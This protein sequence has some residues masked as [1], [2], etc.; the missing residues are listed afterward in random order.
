MWVSYDG[1]DYE[2]YFIQPDTIS[3]TLTLNSDGTFSYTPDSDFNGQV[4]FDYIVSDGQGGQDTATVTVNVGPVNDAPVGLADTITTAFGTAVTLNVL[5]NDTDVDADALTVSGVTQGTNGSVV[6]NTDN[7]ITYTP[8]SGFAGVD[9]FTYIANDGTDDAFPTT[10]TVTVN[11]TSTILGTPGDDIL[12]GT[13]MA[14]SIDGLG[15]SDWIYGE[16][17]DDHLWGGDGI[18]FLYGGSDDDYLHGQ[19]GEDY[20]WGEGGNDHLYGGDGNDRLYGGNGADLL[21]GGQG[22]DALDGGEFTGNNP[23]NVADYQNDP[24][25]AVGGGN[26]IEAEIHYN[27]ANPDN[28]FDTSQVIDGWG[29]IDTINNITRF[30]GSAF[31]DKIT[32]DI[33]DNDN[34]SD[35][36]WY[37]AGMDG[38]DEIIGTPGEKIRAMYLEDPDLNGD[39]FGVNINLAAGT[40]IDGWGNIDTLIDIEG[41]SGSQYNDLLLGSDENDGFVGT[42]GNDSIDGAL[43]WDWVSYGWFSGQVNFGGVDIDLGS[44]SAQGRDLTGAVLFTDSL[45]NIEGAWGTDFNDTLIGSDRGDELVGEAGDDIL[46]GGLGDDH[47]TGG[48]GNDILDGGM[49]Q[50]DNPN[51]MADYS[52]DPENAVG[53][54]N[55]IEAEI[56]Y[57]T[58]NPVN[59]FDS[60]QVIDGWG[61]TDSLK[62]INR[63]KGSA[64]DDSITIAIQDAGGTSNL[65][66]YVAGMA[67]NDM[68]TGT[69]GESVR[70][71]YFEDP[72]LNG[73]GFGVN[74]D[75]AAGTAMDGWGNTDTLINI[76]GVSGSDFNDILLGSDRHDGFFG[77]LGN[78]IIDGRGNRDYVHYGGLDDRGD[79]NGVHIDLATGVVNG[80]NSNSEILFTD[81]LI[82][83]TNV[84]GSIFNDTITGNS[85]DNWLQGHDGDDTIT[86]GDGYDSLWGGQGNDSLNGAVITDNHPRTTADYGRDPEYANPDVSMAWNNGIFAS[87]QYDSSAIN[88]FFADGSDP[89]TRSIVRDGWGTID[90]IQDITRFKGSAFNDSMTISIV[91]QNNSSDLKWYL[92]GLNGN[93]V[94]TGTDG[95]SISAMYLD[96]PK[97]VTIDLFD[98]PDDIF[99]GATN[100]GSGYAID[101]WEKID[102]LFNIH[103]VSGS[104]H[105][106]SIEGSDQGDTIYGSFGDDI[107]DGQAG[108]DGLSYVFMSYGSLDDTLDF[109]GVEIDLEAGLARGLNS[110]HTALFTDTFTNIEWFGGSDKGDRIVGDGLDNRLSGWDGDD[111]LIGMGGNDTLIGEVGNDILEG[112]Q[113]N[114]TLE[115]GQGS[116]F[117]YGGE[118]I[119]DI[120]G[121]SN[122]PGAITVF[123]NNSTSVIDG[124]GD[125]DFLF[126]IEWIIGSRYDDR[127]YGD[128][129]FMVYEGGAGSDYILGHPDVNRNDGMVSYWHDNNGQ[130]VTVNLNVLN[131][132]GEVEVLDGWGNIDYLKR[133]DGIWGSGAVDDL[134]GRDHGHETF[135]GGRGNDRI[136]GGVIDFSAGEDGNTVVYV[137]D[138][139]RAPGQPVNGVIVTLTYDGTSLTGIGYDGWGDTDN[140]SNI[141]SIVG[142]QYNDRLVINSTDGYTGYWMLNGWGGDDELIGWAGNRSAAEYSDS[143]EGINVNL[144]SGTAEDGWGGTDTLVNINGIIGSDHDDFILVNDQS[145]YLDGGDED[146]LDTV[147]YAYSPVAIHAAM[148]TDMMSYE[149]RVSV[150][151]AGS[152]SKDTLEDIEYIIGTD[153]NDTFIGDGHQFMIFEGNDGSDDLDGGVDPDDDEDFAAS[154]WNDPDAS[155]AVGEGISLNLNMV[156]GAGKVEVVDGWGNIDYL[157]NIDGVIGTQFVDTF[158]G[159]NGESSWFMGGDGGDFINGGILGAD[160]RG[161][162]AV[163]IWDPS[164]IEATLTYNNLTGI[165]GMV[166]DGWG[167]QDTLTN[168]TE[169]MGSE[170]DDEFWVQNTATDGSNFDGY[171]RFE[172]RAGND[173]IHGL[174]DEF[175]MALYG[176]SISGVYVDLYDE[177]NTNPGNGFAHDGWGGTDLLYGVNHVQGSEYDDTLLGNDQ[178]NRLE[179]DDGDDVLEG[180]GG[181]DTLIGEDDH[182]TLRGGQGNDILDGG[183]G[184]DVLDGGEGDDIL[185]GGGGHDTL[186]GGDGMFD[187]AKYVNSPGPVSLTVVNGGVLISDGYGSFDTLTGIEGV[188]GSMHNDSF[189]GD[190]RSMNCHGRQGSDY[191]ENVTVSYWYD[192]FTINGAGLDANL[193]S[194]DPINIIDGW[195]DEDT[196]VNVSS[197]FGSVGQDSLVGKDYAFNRFSGNNGADTIDGGLFNPTVGQGPGNGAIYVLD[198]LAVTATLTANGGGG[199]NGTAQDGWGYTDTLTNI[200]LLV[201]SVYDDT[202]TVSSDGSYTGEW[203]LKG[204][205]GNDTLAGDPNAPTTALYDNDPNGVEVHLSGDNPHTVEIENGYAHDGWGGQDTLTH[206]KNVVGSDYWDTLIGD[207]RDNYL[208][209]RGDGDTLVGNDG[210]DILDGGDFS[211]RNPRNYADYSNDP[212]NAVGVGNGIEAVL[213][214]NPSAG[215]P[216][217]GSTVVDGWGDTDTLNNIARIKGS[218][219]NDSI[220]ITVNDPTNLSNVRW[221]A[222]GNGGDD[223]IQGT[224]GE[225]VRAMYLDDDSG[226]K[227][228]LSNGKVYQGWVEGPGTYDF[229]D[230][231][232]NIQAVSGTDYNDILLGSDRSEGFFGTLGNDTIDG[233]GGLDWLSY[234]WMDGDGGFIGVNIDLAS[235]SAIGRNSNGVAIFTDTL[236][237]LE[238]VEGSMFSDTIRGNAGNNRLAGLEG[239]DHIF[240]GEGYD[241]LV[242]DQG[243]DR[244][245]GAVFN[246]RIPQNTAS[247][248]DDPGGI[249][250]YIH[251]DPSDSNPFAG[252]YV[253][254]GW[255]DTDTLINIA[256]IKGSNYDDT[257]FIDIDDPGNM[258]GTFWRIWGQGGND[259]ITGT[260]GERVDAMY[261]DDPGSVNI[262]LSTG[263]AYDGWGGTDTLTNIRMVS[264]SHHGDD[265]LYGSSGDN[266]FYGSFGNDYIFGGD[267][268]DWVVYGWLDGTGNF[269]GISVFL[270]DAAVYGYDSD[271]NQMFSDNVSDVEEVWGTK[272]DD[273]FLGNEL[274][275]WF[276]GEAG[277]DTLTG[278]GGDD[279]FRFTSSTGIDTVT[280]FKAG[281]AENDVLRFDESWANDFYA[282]GTHEYISADSLNPAD[283]TAY[284]IIGVTDIIGDWSNTADV[285]NVS[286][287]A[288]LGDGTNDGTYFV[289]GNGTDARVYIW[290]GDIVDN[291]R[292][293]DS[294][295]RHFITLEGLTDIS[296]LGE[297]HFQFG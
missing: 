235:G 94:L 130:G 228:D 101:G 127:F 40:A 203:F 179:G 218:E 201:G 227:A 65:K 155:G 134:T 18:D 270:D 143:P 280:D 172:G 182:D 55:G 204:W 292:V 187:V 59:P 60:S 16:E 190:G 120:A 34:S 13:A 239:D 151:K 100:P 253:N 234:G 19:M 93:D 176:D 263:I 10:V 63:I 78:D 70:A 75:L 117:L 105:V 256:R 115:G 110:L 180:M 186:I 285:L 188:H 1:S 224:S 206:I 294:E 144:S 122:D 69:P 171:W 125:T 283:P 219:F 7:T 296:A 61:D 28:P 82:N 142:S 148:T 268:D 14:D 72:D 96:D 4:S 86:G 121:Y 44:G 107:I 25:N 36:Y 215:N 233:G 189:V 183:W 295:L 53:A 33:T 261:L 113:G 168:V 128:G 106:D 145:N 281:G 126:D 56:H 251:Y 38:A 267:G 52:D 250:A 265:Q 84:Y 238:E 225:R 77:S 79:F 192:P 146:L 290:E 198:P 165:T 20:L 50:G 205:A 147:S 92:W 214:Y 220:T 157:E 240:G 260:A 141:T 178:Y 247:Y 67:G 207:D 76:E 193:N 90:S 45:V 216:F 162:G 293:D 114:D 98:D 71:M 276:A 131:G 83:I 230:T 23:E 6:I 245:E 30:R 275:N 43:G 136:D 153:F 3:G 80:I 73:D 274:A 170:F 252:S 167:K 174:P 137:L 46:F 109:N 236:T 221:Y 49:M 111:T 223:Y 231:L 229:V 74:I 255:G 32:I 208:N 194:A 47:L 271:G 140:L 102:L 133:I 242:G 284:K 177:G 259:T 195:G 272:F 277:D 12:F 159:K 15:G 39:G 8:A 222:W 108:Y 289:A 287:N 291:G 149:T 129:R 164:G 112:G 199:V 160:H 124:W 197:I 42:Y 266:G 264:G 248:V 278:N 9:S 288:G 269:D 64:F 243:N 48:R 273:T 22:N 5:A 135:A 262:D 51:K 286:V 175:V 232:T 62:N 200:N 150:S 81:T 158:V 184:N 29:D 237:N 156:N 17:D 202:L 257:F 191:F 132:N 31:D 297:G 37:V 95:E 211:G 181:N 169:I 123:V 24:M 254:D 11:S 217:T 26:G 88:P 116:D 241:T 212:V 35:L 87:I 166:T 163:Y 99:E 173:I 21:D 138:P 196:L 27:T 279:V 185:E 68:I 54:G 209:G 139:E 246:S 97:G 66:W 258:D 58:A 57:N 91:D 103:K 104:N 118:G 152:D 282:R 226:V 119:L 41:V 244:I 161:N 85:E 2:I 213:Q 210:N 249:S 154:F 89:A